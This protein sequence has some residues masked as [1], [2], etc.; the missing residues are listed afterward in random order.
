MNL[1]SLARL[2]SFLSCGLILL[3]LCSCSPGGDPAL[4]GKWKVKD[5][6]EII[7]IRKDGTWVEAVDKELG[8]GTAKWEWDG[9]NRIRVS[10]DTKLVGKASGVMKVAINGDTLILKDEDGAVEYTRVK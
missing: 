3:V 8:A 4:I 5:S 2:L 10:V 1:S 6:N 9:T 7:E